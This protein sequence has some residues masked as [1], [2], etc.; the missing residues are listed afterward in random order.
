[1]IELTPREK[2]LSCSVSL[3][4]PVTSEP[5]SLL[6]CHHLQFLCDGNCPQEPLLPGFW[7]LIKG[8]AA[9]IGTNADGIIKCRL[10]WNF[11][12]MSRDADSCDVLMKQDPWEDT[13]CLESVYINRTQWTVI[14]HL[15]RLA[16]Q[17]FFV[18]CLPLS[19]HCWDRHRRELLLASWLALV[20]PADLC[21]F[22]RGLAVSAGSC[23]CCWFV[24]GILTLLNWSASILTN[25]NWNCPKV[26]PLNRSTFPCPLYRLFS[27]TLGWWARRGR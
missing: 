26:L 13:R 25:G 22:G 24:F 11:L 6:L 20:T 27:P 4:C 18:L 15:H 3:W 5:F 9:V 2:S 21:W 1:M 14:G 10:K 12:D 16:L 23:H 8:I 17:Y 7:D 19:P